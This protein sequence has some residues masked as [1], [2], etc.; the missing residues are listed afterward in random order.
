MS[1]WR[2]V[3]LIAGRELRERALRKTYLIGTAATLAVVVAV[4]VLPAMLAEDG[5]GETRL[6]IVGD[7]PQDLETLVAASLPEEREL[8]VT[9]LDDRE[10]AEA[11]LGD[12]A[13][14]AV[15]VER[16]ELLFHGR[17][18]LTLQAALDGV[19][20]QEAF[21]AGLRELGLD[22]HQAA[23]A[24]S[25]PAPLETVDVTAEAAGDEAF[26]VAI[27]ATLLLIIGVQMSGAQLLNG[28]LEEKS[29][30]VVEI[31]VSTARPWQLLTGKVLA[32]SGLAFAQLA[33]MVT[34]ALIT[35]HLVDAFPLPAATGTVL[36]VS[37]VMLVA[38]FLFYA[39]LFTV[40]GTMAS[41]VEDAQSAA[42]P[43]YIAMW[44]TYGA[45]S[46]TVLPSPSGLV[47]QVLT[48]LPPTAPFVVPARVAL[49]E[50]PM[51]QLPVA[52]AVT[53][54]GAVAVLKLAGR[55]YAATL[56]AGGKLTW[57]AALKV[58]PV[59]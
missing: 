40:A 46:I 22:Q 3:R 27:L 26:V 32:T 25:P 13:I 11:A 31:L 30:R 29:N 48:Y 49:G 37:T 19:L 41:T 9:G 43:L 44:G 39:A 53:L 15:L 7:A 23:T 54:A 34:V 56:L 45:V 6:G 14:D 38:G 55:L 42:T 36:W 47:A 2:M 28:A 16:R 58:E 8:T 21:A 10:A 1:P 35:N 59:R 50:L 51:W 4:I 57:N 33:L 52:A 18:D 24:L 5:P 20:R 12:D 17:P